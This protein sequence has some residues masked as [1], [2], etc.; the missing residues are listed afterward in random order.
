M[1][2]TTPSR[3]DWEKQLMEILMEH[4]VFV[5]KDGY[6][7]SSIT[8]LLDVTKLK[9]FI[10]NLLQS[11]NNALVAEIEKSRHHILFH[12]KYDKKSENFTYFEGFNEALDT[13][14]RIIQEK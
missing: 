4:T 6:P 1:T 11:H 13:I 14:I 8:G 3:E 10:R 2:P 12:Q 9:D 7:L 5:S